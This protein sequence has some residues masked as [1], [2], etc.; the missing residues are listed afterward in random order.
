MDCFTIAVLAFALIADP[1]RELR[2]SVPDGLGQNPSLQTFWSMIHPP[3]V[4]A[5]YTTLLFS[6]SLVVG[7]KLTSG[8]E[9][10][11]LDDRVLWAS[12]M[13][14]TLAISFGGA[15]AYETLGWGGYWAWDP[16]ETSAL[17]P[18][19]SLTA[20][21]FTKYMGVGRDHDLFATTFSAS[22]VF[23]TAYIAR[24]ATAPSLHGYGTF[25]GGIFLLLLAVLPTLISLMA[26]RRGTFY[27]SDVER[28]IPS[29][30]LADLTFWSLIF[31][32]L[33]NLILLFYQSFASF[34]GVGVQPSPQLHNSVSLPMLIVFLAVIVVN[35]I[36]ERPTAKDLLFSLALLL[37]IG[38][39]CSLLKRPTG[40]VLANVG[41]PFVLA[42]FAA[43]AY[44][45]SKGVVKARYFRT[46]SNFRHVA[47]FGIAVLLLGVLI[48]SSMQVSATEIVHTG[49]SFDVLELKLSVVEVATSPSDQQIF[50]AP[51]G[52]VPESIDTKV[53]YTS[54]DEPSGSRIIFLRYY[55]AFDRFVPAPSIHKSVME[56]IY[57]V[58]SP[59]ETVREATASAFADRTTT[60]PSDVGI[61]IKRI[62]AVSL[63]WLGAVILI[64][65]NLPFM[66][67]QAPLQAIEEN[68]ESSWKRIDT[69]P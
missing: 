17:I 55:P 44:R 5:A 52:M 51:Y 37:V 65:G 57:I 59:T 4:F 25:V 24:S 69:G 49:E 23:F 8:A 21:L 39:A 14:L 68:L 53:I 29:Y 3:L 60:T 15:W 11:P 45:V 32:A 9:T 46:Y 27:H 66:F 19:L 31:V 47:F 1:F 43:T 10:Q 18:W 50:L 36:K 34:F 61:T 16:L 48:S 67:V 26:A 28:G 7:R 40:N 42:L 33:A 58:A 38:L 20:L 56:D 64:I 35:C 12:W 30:P 2:V 6:Y 13:L 62:P 22:A 41:L 63:V 54:S